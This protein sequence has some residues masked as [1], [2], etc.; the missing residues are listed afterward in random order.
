MTRPTRAVISERERHLSWPELGWTGPDARGSLSRDTAVVVQTLFSQAQSSIL[1]AGFRFDH[2]ASSLAPLHEAMRDRGVSVRI[3][4]DSADAQTFIQNNWPFGFPH[5][6]L[7][8]FVAGDGVHAVNKVLVPNAKNKELKALLQKVDPV[9]K[10][11]LEH[12]KALQKQ[13]QAK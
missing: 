3:Y 13:L 6:T 4:G 12:A 10:K 8:A 7:F 9:L 1:M 2:G 11:H 5:P